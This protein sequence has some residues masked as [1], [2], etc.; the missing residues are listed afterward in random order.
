MPHGIT[1]ARSV[2]YA[3]T[4]VALAVVYFLAGKLGLSLAFLHPNASLVWPPTGIALTA[5]LLFGLRVWP[6]ILLGAFLA[7][8]TTA[9]SAA[10]SLAI[11]IGNTLEGVVGAYLV[12]RFAGGREALL[13]APDFFRFIALAA[14]GST[15]VSPTWGVTSLTLGGFAEWAAYGS[16]W[17]TWWLGDVTGNLVVAPFLLA[18]SVS[19]WPRWDWGRAAEAALLGLAL[20]LVGVVVFGGQFPSDVKNY[21]LE[22]LCVP[23]FVWAAFRF[24]QRGAVTA[25]VALSGITVWGTLSGFGPFVRRT[26]NESLLLL[27]AFMGVTAIMTLALAALVSEGRRAE[28][29][30]RQLAV[31]DPL[32]GLANYRQLNHEIAGEI[33]R[34][35]RTDRPFALLLLDL[36]GLK[37]INDRHGHLVGSRALCRVADAL[38][39]SCRSIDIPAR[40]GGDE[41]A[42]VLPETDEAEALQVAQRIMEHV[43]GNPEKPTLAVSVGHAWHPRDGATTEALM[44][45]ADR[46]LY[47]VKARKGRP[48]PPRPP[49]IFPPLPPAQWP[50]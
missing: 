47:E 37:R 35:Q 22:F 49:S 19:P 30:L 41:F 10:T 9:G 14:I 7:N 17:F 32:T 20:V 23:L 11:G 31:T 44:A 26:P 50:G 29:Q 4:L 43:A 16:I 1:G 40:Y 27:Q 48:R 2:R 38:R 28:D 13:R 39:A 3:A 15:M 5:F 34:S 33:Q 8:V 36:D 25:I 42:V 18:W 21:P 6:A 45:T 46:A 24:A 12:N